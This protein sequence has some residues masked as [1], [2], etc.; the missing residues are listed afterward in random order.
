MMTLAE[1]E[2]LTEAYIKREEEALVNRK[3]IASFIA[4]QNA[5][6]QATDK[7]GRAKIRRFTELY[8]PD[9]DRKRREPS[10]EGEDDRKARLFKM[11]KRVNNKEVEHGNICS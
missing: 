4:W 8:D 1:Y 10:P 6:M 2:V 11:L 3:F 7:K 5:Q 9:K